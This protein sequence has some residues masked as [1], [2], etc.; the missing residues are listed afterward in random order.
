MN[1]S[2]VLKLQSVQSAV[3]QL[4]TSKQTNEKSFFSGFF[5]KKVEVQSGAHSNKLSDKERICELVTHNVKPD[6]L[7]KYLKTTENIIGFVNSNNS[8]LHGQCLGNFQ[9]LVGDQDQFIHLWRYEGGYKNLD[10]NIKFLAESKEFAALQRD[11]LPLIRSRHSQHLLKFSYW[12]DIELRN[13]SNIY[14]LRSYH[15]KPGT[16]VEWGNYWAKAI[17][18]RDYKN[19]E[20]FAGM[21][22]QIGELYNVKHIWCYG[23]LEERKEAREVVWQHQQSQ[24]QD[25]VANTVPLIRQM[26]SR[27][28]LPLNI[29]STK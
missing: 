13:G 12:P 8:V 24:W 25:I 23:S 14:E 19:T 11:L 15:L 22:S 1:A 2:K 27:I 17:R 3:R 9:V 21:F 28:M 16:M 20:A 5:D 29:S 7:D 4:A 18:M 6:C 26:T 10:E